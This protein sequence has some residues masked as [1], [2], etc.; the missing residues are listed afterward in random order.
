VRVVSRCSSAV[1]PIFL[2]RSITLEVMIE[3]VVQPE[4]N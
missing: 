3:R 1:A 4:T 2:R